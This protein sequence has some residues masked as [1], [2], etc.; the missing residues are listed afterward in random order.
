MFFSIFGTNDAVLYQPR[1]QRMIMRE[2]TQ[3]P[4]LKQIQTTVADVGKIKSVGNQGDGREGRAHSSQG[5]I[6]L[7]LVMNRCI[8]ISEGIDQPLLRVVSRICDLIA[9]K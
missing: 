5:R 6:L 8:G 3:L 4:G 7:R 9:F 2:P 1:D